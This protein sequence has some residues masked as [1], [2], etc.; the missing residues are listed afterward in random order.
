MNYIITKNK[1]YFESIGDYN[2]CNLEDMI[3]TEVVAVDTETT[4]LNPREGD[5]FA[6]QIGT[7]ENNYLIDCQSHNNGYIPEDVTPYLEGRTL[8]LHNATFDLT[9]FYKHNFYPKKIHDTMVMSMILHNGKTPTYFYRHGFGYVMERELGAIYDKSAQK[10]IHNTQLSNAKNI[11]YSF[12]DVDRLVELAF[13]MW[14]KL[15]AEGTAVAYKENANFTRALAY[16]EN[17]GMPISE[18]RWEE[19]MRLDRIDYKNHKNII[20]KYIFDNLPEFRE[21]QLDLFSD[22]IKIKPLLS[23][24]DQMIPVFKAL[25]ISTLNDEGKDSIDKSIINK[26]NHEFVKMW[27]DFKEANHAVHNQGQKI[28]DKVENGRLYT[29]YNILLDTA[30][31]STRKGGINFLNFTSNER[32]RR[33]FKAK[34]GFVMIGADYSGQENATTASFTQD[35]TMLASIN[36]GL[37]LHCAFA[38][39]IYPE[40][41]DLTDDEIKKNHP[42]K[43]QASKAPRFL[44]AF[45]GSAY[46]LHRNENIPL[47]EANRIEEAFKILHE[48]IYSTAEKNLKIAL[49]KG[50]IESGVGFKL[51]LPYFD[52]FQETQGKLSKF[53][54]AF[55]GQ[56]REGK[57]EY[58][59][60]SED[61]NYIVQDLYAYQH[62]INYKDFISNHFKSVS[63]YRRLVMNNPSQSI[64][65]FQTKAASLRLFEYILERGHIGMVLMC[66]NVHDEILLEVREDLAEE[67]REVLERCMV[68]EGDKYIDT[69]LLKMSADAQIGESWWDVH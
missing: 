6:I 69:T 36:E 25:G 2:Y 30:R 53:D 18:E 67:Y 9:F 64:A 38:R 28:L 56:Y 29:S 57:E 48:G 4:G 8:V 27:L 19:K 24:N 22:D 58:L 11:E 40:L 35:A 21:T 54:K 41:E 37:D 42:D 16:M 55:W 34:P 52:Q 14:D 46:G 12:N 31:I 44:F 33:C 1:K 26:S 65:A 59:A 43:R 68:E 62:Y 61:P 13:N 66:T 3:L 45:G 20:I 63:K 15:K 17:S 7:G 32:T 47:D 10:N 50:Y 39:M 49:E 23:S 5:I 51:Y 60:L